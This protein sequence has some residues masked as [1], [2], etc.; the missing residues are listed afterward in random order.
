MPDN[1]DEE[2]WDYSDLLKFY[3]SQSIFSGNC[4]TEKLSSFISLLQHIYPGTNSQGEQSNISVRPSVLCLSGLDP[5]PCPLNRDGLD[6]LREY[7][8]PTSSY[9]RF[10]YIPGSFQIFFLYSRKL[11]NIFYFVLL[12]FVYK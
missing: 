4:R 8:F 11:S 12:F 2:K 3:D 1:N 6:I 10:F 9:F 7:C 5:T